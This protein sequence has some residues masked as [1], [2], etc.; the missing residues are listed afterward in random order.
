[1][2]EFLILKFLRLIIMGSNEA[3][4]P[5]SD[6]VKLLEDAVSNVLENRIKVQPAGSAP[7]QEE[8]PYMNIAEVAAY[9]RLAKQTIYQK[10]STRS[11]PHYKRGSRLIFRRSEIDQWLL[12]GK[13]LTSIPKRC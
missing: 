6:L 7:S 13:V 11:I 5:I 4:M 2:I 9:T 1:M 10:T 3:E 12:D 8:K